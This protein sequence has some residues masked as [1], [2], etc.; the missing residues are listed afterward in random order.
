MQHDST[1]FWHSR[2]CVLSHHRVPCG[3]VASGQADPIKSDIPQ[4]RHDNSGSEKEQGSRAAGKWN[5]TET[6]T[7]ACRLRQQSWF[8]TPYSRGRDFIAGEICNASEHSRSSASRQ[9]HRPH[10]GRLRLLSLRRRTRSWSWTLA[11]LRPAQALSWICRP[12][13]AVGHLSR[14]RSLCGS[15]SAQTRWTYLFPSRATSFFT[16]YEKI[17]KDR[18][19]WDKIRHKS[20][21][22]R[23]KCMKWNTLAAT[24]YIIYYIIYG[25]VV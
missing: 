3:A 1:F 7:A 18:L 23:W 5:C 8:P 6:Q 14:A 24:L 13:I 9:G 16:A 25:I 2:C 15:T 10:H 19:R 21:K 20:G 11:H 22:P 12:L 17:V 4:H